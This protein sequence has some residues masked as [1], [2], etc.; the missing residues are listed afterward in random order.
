M[1]EDLQESTAVGAIPGV[2][3]RPDQAELHGQALPPRHLGR[4][5]DGTVPVQPLP[6]RLLPV[7]SSPTCHR[8]GPAGGHRRAC[9]AQLVP[10]PR[11]E[12]RALAEAGIIRR[13]R[14]HDLRHAHASWL[15]AGGADLQMV[16]ERL[17]HAS[18]RS[19][20]RYLHTL[21]D[22][23]EWTLAAFSHIRDGH[24]AKRQGPPSRTTR[25][26][27]R[28]AHRQR[29]IAGDRTRSTVT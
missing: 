15:L 25:I 26:T 10:A 28:Y 6:H 17:G 23:D 22:S 3:H 20:E 19:T 18:L 2:V 11:L 27:R 24:L 12:T 21:P 7:P 8:T 9:V 1:P 16:R 5:L 29:A 14:M 13:I 4:I